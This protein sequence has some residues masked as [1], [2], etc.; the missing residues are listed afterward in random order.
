M[1]IFSFSLFFIFSATIF[2]VVQKQHQLLVTLLLCNAAS[3]EVITLISGSLIYSR[4]SA[5][6]TLHLALQNVAK[7]KHEEDVGW[8]EGG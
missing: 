8:G 4:M 3:M 7:Q 1:E 6:C 5:L 2:P